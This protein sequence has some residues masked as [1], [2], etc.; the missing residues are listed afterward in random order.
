MV[1]VYMG[2]IAGVLG[3]ST[4]PKAQPRSQPAAKR[5]KLEPKAVSAQPFTPLSS[6]ELHSFAAAVQ[7]QSL[8]PRLGCAKACLCSESN[9]AQTKPQAAVCQS[10]VSL[11]G[12]A[13]LDHASSPEMHP[14][15]LPAIMPS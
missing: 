4:P 7:V 2:C 10:I 3:P 6:N 1:L 15:V 11:A 5:P 9:S 8:T 14:A 12:V 13:G